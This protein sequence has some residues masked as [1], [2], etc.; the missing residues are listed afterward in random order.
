MGVP[1]TDAAT[2]ETFNRVEYIYAQVLSQYLN[3]R[4]SVNKSGTEGKASPE[5]RNLFGTLDSYA[6]EEEMTLLGPPA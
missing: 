4:D 2:K 6:V 5:L 1:N 3:L